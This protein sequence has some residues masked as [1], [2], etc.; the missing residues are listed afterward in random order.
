MIQQGIVLIRKPLFAWTYQQ[1][2]NRKFELTVAGNM[3][4]K[5]KI[6][7]NNEELGEEKMS[8]AHRPLQSNYHFCDSIIKPFGSIYKIT[9]QYV[10]MSSIKNL[11]AIIP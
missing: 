2:E 5:L 10:I 9:E 4:A 7:S 3:L 6:S 1:K 11:I 8:K